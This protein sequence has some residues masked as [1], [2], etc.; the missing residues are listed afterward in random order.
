MACC[1][2]VPVISG[3]LRQWISSRNREQRIKKLKDLLHAAD[4]IETLT[5]IRRASRS[6]SGSGA[7]S[8]R[9]S[10]LQHVSTLPKRM[11]SLESKEEVNILMENT[12][13][14]Q[15]G[16][17]PVI[18]SWTQLIKYLHK[19]VPGWSDVE[20]SKI[21]LTRLKGAMTNYMILCEATD[22]MDHH[23][24][25]IRIYGLNTDKFFPREREIE[26]FCKLSEKGFGPKLLGLF[27]QGRF[28]EFLEVEQLTKN[29]LRDETTMRQIAEQ[30]CKMHHFTQYFKQETPEETSSY[31]LQ[32]ELW[33]ILEDWRIKAIEACKMIFHPDKVRYIQQLPLQTLPETLA[34]LR[35][36]IGKISCHVCFCHNDVST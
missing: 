33:D 15:I 32:S 8:S 20:P 3:Y 31:H 5:A 34:K 23:R 18:I 35:D 14:T 30:M 29:D 27:K 21:Q 7:L 16:I 24:L 11:F 1:V 22:V 4:Y 2:T 36:R 6:L 10:S 25:L 9:S 26:V 19:L 13:L 28:E 17:E 12:P